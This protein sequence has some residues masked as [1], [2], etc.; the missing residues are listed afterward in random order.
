MHHVR[1]VHAYEQEADLSWDVAVGMRGSDN[2]LRDSVDAALDRLLADG[3]I[4]GIY[5]RYGIEHRP[6]TAGR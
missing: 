4:Q 2:L 6:P 1:L 5:A 3:T